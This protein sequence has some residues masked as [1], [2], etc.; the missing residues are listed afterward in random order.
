MCRLV[1]IDTNFNTEIKVA[2]IKAVYIM[3]MS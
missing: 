2:D 3:L 1:G